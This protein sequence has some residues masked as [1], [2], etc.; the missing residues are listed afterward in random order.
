MEIDDLAADIR[1]GRGTEIV[2]R[3]HETDK[4][5]RS[6]GA[7][8]GEVGRL[9]GLDPGVDDLL[10]LNGRGLLPALAGGWNH[11]DAV[12]ARSEVLDIGHAVGVGHDAA[13][14]LIDGAHAVEVGRTERVAPDVVGLDAC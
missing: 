4:G 1:A 2:E 6:G 13:A 9:V 3:L 5:M 7:E 10:A 14:H 12:L 8:L 11:D